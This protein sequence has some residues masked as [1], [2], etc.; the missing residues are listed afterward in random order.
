MRSVPQKKA[1]GLT[2]AIKID[3]GQV[4]S[5]VDE[6]VRG[7]VEQ[8]LNNLLDAEADRIC[9]ARRYERSADRQD[10]RRR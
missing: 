7:T 4:Q 3:P 8:T 10:T 6:L 5:H 1:A 2:E 9:N